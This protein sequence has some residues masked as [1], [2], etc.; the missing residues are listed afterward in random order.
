MLRVLRFALISLG[1]VCLGFFLAV[2][3]QWTL[4]L[5]WHHTITTYAYTTNKDGDVLQ[6]PSQVDDQGLSFH[7]EPYKTSP[8]VDLFDSQDK[9]KK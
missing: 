4:V 9:D 1:S 7:T 5:D 2:A 3:L 6:V 8:V